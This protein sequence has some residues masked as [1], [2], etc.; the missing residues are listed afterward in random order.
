MLERLNDVPAGIE[1]LKASRKLSKEEHDNLFLPLLDEARRKGRRVRLL[2]Q[3]GPDF[4]GFTTPDAAWEDP[5]LGLRYMGVF[6]A[7]AIVTDLAWIREEA[8]LLARFVM[9]CPVRVFGLQDRGKAIE[10]LRSMPE[11]AAAA[12]LLPDSGTLVVEVQ[13]ALH[14]QDYDALSVTADTWIGAH[15]RLRGLVVHAREFPGW[16]NLE[17][18]LRHVR[19]MRDHRGKVERIALAV[20]GRLGLLA[21]RIGEHFVHAEMKTFAYDSLDAAVAWAETTSEGSAASPPTPEGKA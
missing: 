6:V 11:I 4:G 1:G 15:G 10:W 16:E 8:K 5:K 20:D 13:G 14:A 12:H 18:F 21:P 19:F 9:P 17:S 7:C 3:L 2:Y